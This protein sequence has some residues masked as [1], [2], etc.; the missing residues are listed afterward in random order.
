MTFTTIL[1]TVRETPVEVNT[2]GINPN[3]S[4]IL[5]NSG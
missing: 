1:T 5:K 4:R 2:W 3:G